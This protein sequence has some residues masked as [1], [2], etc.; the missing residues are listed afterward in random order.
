[1]GTGLIQEGRQA[2]DTLPTLPHG[3]TTLKPPSR[4]PKTCLSFSLPSAWGMLGG[5]LVSGLSSPLILLG[6][7]GRLAPLSLHLVICQM[8]KGML[9]L[10][11][12]QRWEDLVR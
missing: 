8:G 12:L 1:M 2:R 9:A 4:S 7:L 3:S 10:P 6:D 11:P 5:P